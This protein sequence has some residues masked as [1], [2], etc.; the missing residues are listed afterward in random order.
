MR[1][2]R[3]GMIKVSLIYIILPVIA[4]CIAAICFLVPYFRGASDGI[5]ATAPPL[6]TNTSD[7]QMAYENEGSATHQEDF[8]YPS[9]NIRDP[10][11]QV[12]AP[13]DTARTASPGRKPSIKLAGIIWD[14]SMSIAIVKDSDGSSHLAHVG[15]TVAGSRI[16]TI[17]RDNIT[18]QSESR[19]QEL[20]L[21]PEWSA[22]LEPDK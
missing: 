17:H 7:K 2:D 8:I 1:S 14:D 22:H 19:I 3:R 9:G 11:A 15:E 10:F 18:I 20:T 16:L 4:I 12:S 5:E 6:R 21:W 13:V